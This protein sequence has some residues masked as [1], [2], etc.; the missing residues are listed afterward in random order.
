MLH[1]TFRKGECPLFQLTCVTPLLLAAGRMARCLRSEI[2]SRLL[3]SLWA[4]TLICPSSLFSI[5]E[6]RKLEAAMEVREKSSSPAHTGQNSFAHKKISASK[7]IIPLHTNL[8]RR[9]DIY[10]MTVASRTLLVVLTLRRAS[11]IRLTLNAVLATRAERAIPFPQWEEPALRS[12][13][14]RTQRFQSTVSLI[15]IVPIRTIRFMPSCLKS[16]SG[17]QWQQRS[18]RV[19]SS[20]TPVVSLLTILSRSEPIILCR[21]LDGEPIRIPEPSTGLCGIVGDNTGERWATCDWRWAKTCW[22]LK[23][24]LHG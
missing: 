3:A 2:V 1:V 11:A 8:F 14:F 21:L 22:A 19:Q 7:D 17:V 5:A 4:M 9:K 12:T 13:T 20:S 10:L 15:T 18:M 24:K 16:T 6:Q 23:A